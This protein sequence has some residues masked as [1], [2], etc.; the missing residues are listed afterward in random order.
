M[1]FDAKKI[2]VDG[3][4]DLITLASGAVAVAATLSSTDDFSV[5]SPVKFTVDAQTGNTEASG[6]LKASGPTTLSD[7]LTVVGLPRFLIP[8]KLV[9]QLP[10]LEP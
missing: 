5:G 7:T 6:T 2:G 9:G 10:C 8:F 1:R 4:V 3:D